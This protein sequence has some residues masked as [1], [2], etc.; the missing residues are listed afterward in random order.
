M[1]LLRTAFE[2]ASSCETKDASHWRGPHFINIV[3]LAVA[4][5]TFCL[6]GWKRADE[7]FISSR[8]PPLPVPIKPYGFCGR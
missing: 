6:Y 3:V 2:T 1:T 5:G 8:S 7:P 4:D